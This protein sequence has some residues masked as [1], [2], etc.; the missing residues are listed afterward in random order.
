MTLCVRT[1]QIFHNIR[2]AL[3]GCQVYIQ[4]LGAMSVIS[5]FIPELDAAREEGRRRVGPLPTA[6]EEREGNKVFL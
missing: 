6:P 1:T 5:G 2:G 3:D 4:D